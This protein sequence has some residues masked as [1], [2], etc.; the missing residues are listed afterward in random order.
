MK[1]TPKKYQFIRER[2][3]KKKSDPSNN[4]RHSA[5]VRQAAY[6]NQDDSAYFRYVSCPLCQNDYYSIFHNQTKLIKYAHKKYQNFLISSFVRLAGTEITASLLTLLFRRPINVSG[7]RVVRCTNCGLLYR[8]PIYR[9][10]ALQKA[11][12]EGYLKFLTG[13]YSQ[14]RID[15]YKYILDKLEFKKRTLDFDR[16]RILDIGCGFGLFLNLMKSWK[17]EPYGL[18]FAEDCVEYAQKEF[19]LENIG[20]GDLEENT[21]EADFF[22]VVT[23]L[24]VAAHLNDPLDMFRK[25]HK[26][27]RPRGLLIIF[28]VNANSLN[29]QYHLDQWAGFSKNHLVFFDTH[30]ITTA[31]KMSGFAS[32]EH[33]YDSRAFDSWSKNGTIP[34]KFVKHFDQF[35]RKE[36]LGDMLIVLATNGEKQ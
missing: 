30:T 5:S 28:T 9:E 34:K 31:L 15:L 11:Y 23:L 29:H 10:K 24:S 7:Y 36:N 22:D 3:D 19:G 8:N 16:H 6:S 12:N 2:W 20:K 1:L 33:Q 32:V 4:N 35:M 21:F 13:E 17:W 27:L 25:I 18:D 14:P 26:I